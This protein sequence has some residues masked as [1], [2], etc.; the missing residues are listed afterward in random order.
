MVSW[1]WQGTGCLL[2]LQDTHFPVLWLFILVL[3]S[4]PEPGPASDLNPSAVG[5]GMAEAASGPQMLRGGGVP[6]YLRCRLASSLSTPG[7][8]EGQHTDGAAPW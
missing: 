1:D 4:I 5:M 3:C 8:P 6:W 2:L 7:G